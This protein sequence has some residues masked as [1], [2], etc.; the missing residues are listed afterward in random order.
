[1][2]IPAGPPPKGPFAIDPKEL[3]KEFLQLQAKTHPDLHSGE[4]K[5]RAEGL[6]SLVNEAYKTLQ[7]PLLRAQ[8]LL[9]LRGIDVA[10]DETLKLDDPDLLMEVMEMRENIEAVEEES[11]L[12]PLKAENDRK[13]LASVKTL[14]EAFKI[15]DM[16]TAEEE[17]VRLRYWV[18]IAESLHSWEKGK[19]VV[20]VH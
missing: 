19:P 3:R 8:Y 14:D 1:M 16:R 5:A 18:N 13:V 4:A 15:D 6:S 12:E 2:T 10:E 17:A 7:N 20:L 9:S 11:Q